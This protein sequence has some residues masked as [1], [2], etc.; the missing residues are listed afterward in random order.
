MP[1][2]PFTAATA[3]GQNPAHEGEGAGEAKAKQEGME[4]GRE[5]NCREGGGRGLAP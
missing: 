2:I 1:S 5:K 4:P 3:C